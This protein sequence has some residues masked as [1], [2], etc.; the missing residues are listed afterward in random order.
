MKLKI[1]AIRD[2]AT[3]QFDRPMFFLADGQAIR[4]FADAVND[5]SKDNPFHQHPD[6]YDL[7][8]LGEYDPDTALI[9]SNP[10][11]QIA[12]GKSHKL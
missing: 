9:T 1:Y 8:Y 11:Q 6:D 5:A 4:S 10:P 7:Y 12:I 3:D 2:R